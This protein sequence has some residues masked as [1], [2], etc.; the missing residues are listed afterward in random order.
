[1]LDYEGI[2]LRFGRCHY[3]DHLEMDCSLP[4]WKKRWVKKKFVK[5]FLDGTAICPMPR[6][7]VTYPSTHRL[8]YTT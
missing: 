3:Y 1:V 4:H 8:G 6:M 2:P 5:E 7:Y